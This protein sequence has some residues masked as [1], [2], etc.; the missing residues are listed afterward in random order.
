MT[1]HTELDIIEDAAVLVYAV[2]RRTDF[3]NISSSRDI[4]DEFASRIATASYTDSITSFMSRL[5]TKWGVRSIHDHDDVR[6]LIRKY[7]EQDEYSARRFLR[8]VRDNNA[9][10]VLEMKQQ[11]QNGD[12]A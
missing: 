9:L 11:Q 1:N 10:V 4:D 12:S 2:W 3:D 6:D 7:D 5:A 8:T